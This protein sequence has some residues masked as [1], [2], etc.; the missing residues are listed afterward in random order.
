[1]FIKKQRGLIGSYFISTDKPFVSYLMLPAKEL[2][3]LSVVFVDKIY[4]CAW[5]LSSMFGVQYL[6]S[7]D[8]QLDFLFQ[9][10]Q[11][12]EDEADVAATKAVKAEQKAEVAEFDENIPWDEAEAAL[13]ASSEETSKVRSRIAYL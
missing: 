3:K 10:L 4:R 11:A 13:K 2:L 1:M 7:H 8:L 12:A 5:V 6:I 9:A